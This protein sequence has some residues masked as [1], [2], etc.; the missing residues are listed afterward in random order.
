[1]SRVHSDRQRHPLSTPGPDDH[2]AAHLREQASPSPSQPH[3]DDSDTHPS[4]PRRT[5]SGRFKNDFVH[6]ETGRRGKHAKAADTDLAALLRAIAQEPIEGVHPITGKSL[7]VIE[8]LA[9]SLIQ[10]A[11]KQPRIALAIMELMMRTGA[12][13]MSAA[14]PAG[15]AATDAATLSDFLGRALRQERVRTA[16]GTEGNG[17]GIDAP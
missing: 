12:V 2:N 17:E 16:N 1:M 14:E 4:D 3:Q 5:R 11:F 15:S 10:I 13:P 7:T 8:G 9:R 6:N